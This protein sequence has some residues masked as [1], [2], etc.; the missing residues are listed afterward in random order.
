ML[1][2]GTAQED[3]LL[4]SDSS[5]AQRCK[6]V[7]NL[8]KNLRAIGA[9]ADLDLPRIAVIGNQSAGKSSL[10]E[11]ISGITVPRDAGT[12]TRCPME[13]RLS[14]S[15]G[16]W[17]CQIS[18]RWEFNDDGRRK[19]EVHEVPF[20]QLITDKNKVELM[21]RRAQAAVLNPTIPCSR[22]LTMSADELKEDFAANGL[23]ASLPFSKNVVC[24]DLTGP[25]LTDL[26]FVDLPGIISNA[27]PDIVKFVEGLVRSHIKGNCLILVCLPMSDDI[28]N[29]RAAR[30]ASEE[31]P[32]GSRTIGV[33]TK[34][35]TLPQGAT[36]SR[37]L[38]LDVIEGRHH[39]LTHG[40]YCTRQPDDEERNAGITTAKARAAEADFFAKTSP[41]CIS[42]HQH[43]FGT[44]SL[45]KNLSKL[46]TQVIDDVLPKLQGEVSAQLSKCTTQL[47][48]LPQQVNTE[49]SAFVLNLVTAF[50]TDVHAHVQGGPSTASLVQKNRAV[51]AQFKRS[52][53]LT[54]PPFIPYPRAEEA[55]ADSMKFLELDEE[56]SSNEMAVDDSM[57]V[58]PKYMYLNDVRQFIRQSITR[59]LPNNVPY[60]A[61]V[62]LI[63][64]FQNQWDRHSQNCFDAVD[65]EFQRTLFH[66]IQTKFERYEH[67]KTRIQLVM[68]ELVKHRRD[69]TLTY[70]Q[71]LLKLETTPFTQNDHYLAE[72]TTKTLARYKDARAGKVAPEKATPA[73]NFF[74]NGPFAES[75]NRFAA[76]VPTPTSNLPH[77]LVPS[78]EPS[79]TPTPTPTVSTENSTFSFGVPSA[80]ARPA[81]QTQSPAIPIIFNGQTVQQSAAP[82]ND[83]ISQPQPSPST[84]AFATGKANGKAKENGSTNPLLPPSYKT[85]LASEAPLNGVRTLGTSPENSSSSVTTRKPTPA[86]AAGHIMRALEQ[87]GN[88]PEDV[89]AALAA[90]AKIGYNVLEVDLGKLNPPDEYEE[91][92][93]V[94]AEVRAY[95][96]VAYKRVIDYV[97]LSI[98]HLFLYAF[99][100]DLQAFLLNKLGLGGPNATARCE[101]YLV[102]DAGVVAAREE[103]TSKKKRLESVQVELFNFGL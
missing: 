48:R 31:D 68:R 55:E 96:Q 75:S 57:A 63:Q 17:F 89:K 64:A 21:L 1:P 85:Q 20:G 78:R 5:Y 53:R 61:K 13:C 73:S 9:Q 43:R 19:D 56:E 101:A 95:F 54:A 92:L 42:T 34:P 93:Q 12:C 84:P 7:L 3:L 87:P 77:P 72:K 90:L 32:S 65:T 14:S 2:H 16:S 11:A 26:S 98:D 22:F 83:G 40:Y 39:A 50:C 45:I 36:K 25:E 81:A 33:L 102:E 38:W 30:L 94:M 71:S 27:E 66:I 41:W 82:T 103:L 79:A 97:P 29:Q 60:P 70:I 80:F 69:A 91:E 74:S 44:P 37:E 4:S 23:K 67:L 58:Q 88:N 62:A 46:L 35:D 28:D 52:I 8:V 86:S 10:V 100:E 51:Y 6:Q 49:P 15:S 24:I 59:E 47:D 99:A 76:F 18:I